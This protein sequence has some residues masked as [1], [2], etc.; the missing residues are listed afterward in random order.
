MALNGGLCRQAVLGNQGVGESWPGF[1]E[2][3]FD[4]LGPHRFDRVARSSMEEGKQ[5]MC[6]REVM[7]AEVCVHAWSGWRGVV[8]WWVLTRDWVGFLLVAD[9]IALEEEGAKGVRG[10]AMWSSSDW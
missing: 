8:S 1:V 7:Y 2:T 6:G 5:G 10:L 9:G 4:S 3:V